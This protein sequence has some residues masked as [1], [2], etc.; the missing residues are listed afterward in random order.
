MNKGWD[1]GEDRLLRYSRLSARQKLE[2]LGEM[3]E[4]MKRCYSSKT[5]KIFWRLR[6]IK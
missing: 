5:K 1:I 3:H 4:F 6:G 2:W